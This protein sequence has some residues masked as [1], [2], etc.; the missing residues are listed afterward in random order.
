MQ[1]V[2]IN[3]SLKEEEEEK[4]QKKIIRSRFINNNTVTSQGQGSGF[5]H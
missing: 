5:T 1:C 4:V 2:A 3:N